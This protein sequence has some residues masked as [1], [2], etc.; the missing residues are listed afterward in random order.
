MTRLDSLFCCGT[1][2]DI[3]F[4]RLIGRVVAF[5]IDDNF[6]L[7]QAEAAQ[8]ELQRQN[9]RLQR[10]ERELQEVILN[11]LTD[12]W[13]G[14][15]ASGQSG[16]IEARLRRFDGAY[17]WFLFRATPSL[18]HGKVVKWYGTNTDI[19]ARKTA[20]QATVT[21][22]SRRCCGGTCDR[23]RESAEYATGVSTTGM[24]PAFA[25]DG[26]RYAGFTRKTVAAETAGTFHWG[27]FLPLAW[28]TAAFSAG[29]STI[30][31][32]RSNTLSAIFRRT[33]GSRIIF[34]THCLPR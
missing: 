4:L 10:G 12:Y 9:E 16:E 11:R 18:D 31:K 24:F 30:D 34:S 23:D 22:N 8:R 1:T 21:Q 14:V 17:R 6:N 20:E 26:P 2:E 19:E 7:R 5:A 15:L 29:S 33:W 3:G 27:Y 25:R 28:S 32:V 13:R